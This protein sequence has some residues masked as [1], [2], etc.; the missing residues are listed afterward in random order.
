[1][2]WRALTV[3]ALALLAGCGDGD[4]EAAG[5]DYDLL[6]LG[7]GEV[8]A[9]S[10][11]P[12][13]VS[14]TDDGGLA[15]TVNAP[16]GADG[17]TCSADVRAIA[18]DTGDGPAVAAYVIRSRTAIVAEGTACTPGDPQLVDVAAPAD[19]GATAGDEVI[20]VLTHERVAV[21]G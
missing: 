15:V 5:P 8:I 21:S 17:S 13:D 16:V 4:S 12:T 14:A 18:F 2:R 9:G 19:L 10:V 3:V 20:I 7:A 6:D 11:L 1:M